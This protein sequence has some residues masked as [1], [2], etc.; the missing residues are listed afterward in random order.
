MAPKG[1]DT[2]QDT[3]KS[4]NTNKQRD[5]TAELERTYNMNH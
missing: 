2:N 4:K 1:R 3:P 5:L